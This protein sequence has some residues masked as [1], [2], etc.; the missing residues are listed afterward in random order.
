MTLKTRKILFSFFLLTFIIATPLI[1]LYAAGYKIGKGFLIQKTGILVIESKPEGAKIYID[2]KVQQNFFSKALKREEG[3]SRT[4]AK[5]KN[6]KPGEY[7]VRLELEGYWPWEKKEKINPGQST[8]LEN[9]TLFKKDLPLMLFPGKF[10]ELFISPNKKYLSAVKDGS[11]SIFNLEK[12]TQEKTASASEK[13]IKDHQ[14]SPDNKKLIADGKLFEI[15]G[16]EKELA[17]SKLIGE[18]YTNLKWDG[19]DGNKFFYTQELSVFEYNLDNNE[20]TLILENNNIGDYLSKN[21]IFYYIE[22]QGEESRLIVFDTEKKEASMTINIPCSDY[23]FINKDNKYLNLYDTRYDILYLIDPFLPARQL[24]DTIN[25]VKK[26]F[27]IDG[28]EML[29][30]ND[31]EIWT[32]DSSNLNRRLITRI[33]EKINFASWNKE[34][35]Y[36]IYSTDKSINVINLN[37]GEKNITTKLFEIDEIKNLHIGNKNEIIYFYSRIGNQEGFYKLNIQ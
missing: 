18:N 28:N 11:L 2:E 24:R 9:I 1:S 6:M 20:K 25:N 16:S 27:W 37:S 3:F 34:K 14:W 7:S 32:Y 13:A 15:N 22:K 23:K 31:F 35:K 5:I 36:I 4:P 10:E 33:S 26:T 29:Y 21:N 8:I 19:N 30:I 17:L 12:E